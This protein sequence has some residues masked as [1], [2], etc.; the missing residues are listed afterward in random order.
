MCFKVSG[1]LD[2][3]FFDKHVL[4]LKVLGHAWHEYH[5][6]TPHTITKLRTGLVFQHTCEGTVKCGLCGLSADGILL[7]GITQFA[8]TCNGLRR[9]CTVRRALL[10]PSLQY[11]VSGKALE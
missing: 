9:Q 7:T 4:V 8:R 2:I 5:A 1:L 6:A 3:V 11:D 10:Q